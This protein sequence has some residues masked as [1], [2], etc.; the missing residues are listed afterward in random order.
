MN[1]HADVDKL[2]VLDGQAPRTGNVLH[3]SLDGDTGIAEGN[4][5]KV[6]VVGAHDIEQ[7]GVVLPV[8]DHFAIAG[9]HNGDGLVGS[10]VHI[11]IIG[12]IPRR[13]AAGG[14]AAVELVAVLVSLA[15]IDTGMYQQCVA[16][17]YAGRRS[18]APVP[19]QACH[20]VS[21]Q[22]A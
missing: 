10:A 2:A 14:V 13:A 4:A 17:P 11:Q 12:A 18:T 7:H 9:R 5:L 6:R 1:R 3:A 21:L 20:V 16:G 22:Q 15:G 19:T 8:K